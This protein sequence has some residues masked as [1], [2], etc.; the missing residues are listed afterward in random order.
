[1]R[2]YR[3]KASGFRIE[4]HV[5]CLFRFCL[6]QYV[7][8][9]LVRSTGDAWTIPAICRSCI[10]VYVGYVYGRVRIYICQIKD[11]CHCRT[12]KMGWLFV[13]VNRMIVFRFTIPVTVEQVS[14]PWRTVSLYIL[15][16][17]CRAYA[18]FA[19]VC[20]SLCDPVYYHVHYL[21]LER[22]KCRCS[23]IFDIKTSE[24]GT[25]IN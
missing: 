6:L 24:N 17:R 10:Y 16:C 18:N 4:S 14:H 3:L 2:R 8:I 1:M 13:V 21:N 15:W 22:I 12:W 23:F 20:N 7:F 5:F 11:V 9:L 19:S 25:Y